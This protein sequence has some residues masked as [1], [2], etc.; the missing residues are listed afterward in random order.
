MLRSWFSVQINSHQDVINCLLDNGADVNKLNDDGQSVLSACF[1]LLYPVESFL[2]N[3]VDAM[4]HKAADTPSVGVQEYKSTRAGKTKKK[5][6]REPSELDAKIIQELPPHGSTKRRKDSEQMNDTREA[7][8]G[9]TNDSVIEN[10]LENLT[11][12]EPEQLPDVDKLSVRSKSPGNR[13][14]VNSLAVTVSDQQM[15]KCATT[16]STNEM[17]VGRDRSTEHNV[18]SK[19]TVQLHALDKS[20]STF[21]F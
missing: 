18:C 14:M 1:T 8:N 17:N 10:G 3:A 4:S 20:R 12:N 16:S 19:G 13:Q 9:R 15:A 7:I 21:F 5:I 2:K 6:L 11:V